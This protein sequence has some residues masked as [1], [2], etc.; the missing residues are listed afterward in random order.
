MPT[1]HCYNGHAL[2]TLGTIADLTPVCYGDIRDRKC[3]DGTH[4]LQPDLKAAF[5]T[6]LQVS[7]LLPPP[8]AQRF[9]ILKTDVYEKAKQLKSK[10]S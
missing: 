5:N 3:A 9:D 2:L 4:W 10:L 1:P 7:N 8:T 6:K